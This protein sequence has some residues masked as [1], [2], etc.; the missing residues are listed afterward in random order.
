VVVTAPSDP[1]ARITAG[2]GDML[3]RLRLYALGVGRRAAP[4]ARRSDRGAQLARRSEDP[5][6]AGE[7]NARQRHERG[8]PA[9]K[10]GRSGL[11]GATAAVVA[12]VTIVAIGASAVPIAS[13]GGGPAPAP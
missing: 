9:K 11:A 8:E 12:L 10:V 7:M 2:Q 13:A 5:V 4:A 1:K 6:V 3:G